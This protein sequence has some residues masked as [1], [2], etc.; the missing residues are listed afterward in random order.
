MIRLTKSDGSYCDACGA[1]K[2][3]YCACDEEIA[4]YERLK[5][6]ENTGLSP[7]DLKPKE[8]ITNAD[9]IRSIIDVKEM[10]DYLLW[11]YKNVLPMYTQSELGLEQWMK[12][13]AQNG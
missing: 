12:Q 5:A 10:T 3:Q 11:I 7:E 9:K 1:Q 6:Y 4:M 2:D 13:E 8:I